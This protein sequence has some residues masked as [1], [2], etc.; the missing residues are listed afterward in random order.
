VCIKLASED[1]YCYFGQGQALFGL[2]RYEEALTAYKKA[3]QLSLPHPDPR[4]Y[5]EQGVVYERLAQQTYEKEKK[6]REGW[7]PTR[8]SDVYGAVGAL[9]KELEPLE[10]HIKGDPFYD[11]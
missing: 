8:E 11:L 3:Q 1:P 7:E 6:A 4:F 9:E 2:E 5:H 10:N